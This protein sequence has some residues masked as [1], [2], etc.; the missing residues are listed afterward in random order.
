MYK[1]GDVDIKLAIVKDSGKV[2]GRNIYFR[3]KLRGDYPTMKDGVVRVAPSIK[4]REIDDIVEFV[5][6]GKKYKCVVIGD[7]FSDVE[8]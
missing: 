4:F 3:I 7:G 8:D 2:V 6:A 1:C 5:I